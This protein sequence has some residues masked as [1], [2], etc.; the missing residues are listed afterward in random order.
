[1]KVFRFNQVVEFVDKATLQELE[2]LKREINEAKAIGDLLMPSY[3]RLMI[4][5]KR[6]Q[7]ALRNKR[8]QKKKRRW[9]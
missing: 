5:V 7:D 9:Y 4:A 8:N 3:R 2:S 6:R 1:M